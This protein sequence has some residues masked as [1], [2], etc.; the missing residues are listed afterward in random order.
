MAFTGD[1]VRLK[2]HF[3]SFDGSSVDPTDVSLRIMDGATYSVLETIS[4]DS[5]SVVD[6]G[7]YQYDYVIPTS[8][9]YTNDTLV[10]EFAGTYSNKPILARGIIKRKFV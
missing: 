9:S 7:T 8:D 3:M 6:V 5:S 2:V 1:T 10:Y 4:I